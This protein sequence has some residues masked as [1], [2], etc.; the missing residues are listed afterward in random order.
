MKA[1]TLSLAMALFLMTTS[2][3]LVGAASLK[4]T[5]TAMDKDLVTM[6]CGSKAETLNVGDTVKVKTTETKKKAIEGC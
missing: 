1:F 6:D 4:C 5:V 3:A 2:A